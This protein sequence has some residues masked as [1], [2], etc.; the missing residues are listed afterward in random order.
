[1]TALSQI[2]VL[3]LFE[4]KQYFGGR[5]SK[6]KPIPANSPIY[7]NSFWWRCQVWV[8]CFRKWKQH[9]N[10]LIQIKM[11]NSAKPPQI[12]IL[13]SV[14]NPWNERLIEQI[15][16]LEINLLSNLLYTFIWSIDTLH[17]HLSLTKF[18][19]FLDKTQFLIRR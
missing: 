17:S 3:E 15:I 13:E 2:N 9:N 4:F 7:V 11:P 12:C 5:F 6:F 1:M 16:L 14:N 8:E 10:C 18:I 19:E